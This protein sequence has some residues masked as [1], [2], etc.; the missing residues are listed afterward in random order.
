MNKYEVAAFVADQMV[1]ESSAIKGYEALLGAGVLD[2]DSQK[3][4]EEIISDE[5]NHLGKLQKVV[6]SLD[7][8]EPAKDSVP[9]SEGE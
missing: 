6:E 3:V 1:G 8:I 7:G 2:T 4:I 9:E 5:K